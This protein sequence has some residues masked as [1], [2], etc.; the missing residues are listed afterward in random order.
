MIDHVFKSAM[1]G[2]QFRDNRHFGQFPFNHREQKLLLN[3]EVIGQFDFVAVDGAL[4]DHQRYGHPPE[5]AG[6][7][8][9]RTVPGTTYPCAPGGSNDYVYIFAQPQM[10]K[11]F[12]GV[13][14][15][16]ALAD[17]PRYATP[18]ARW[19]NRDAMNAIVA[20]WTR[21]RTK[22]EVMKLMGATSP[23]RWH[24]WQY[25][26][27]MRE[28]CFVYVIVPVCALNRSPGMWPLLT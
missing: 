25:F 6:N 8:L 10:W 3:A 5:R 12:L 24:S 13:L 23:G 1:I 22:H 28:T 17:D 7:Q 4:R 20:E 15:Q 26:C 19:E 11:A 9:G 27:M 18:A 2:N 14:G 21:Q 16:P